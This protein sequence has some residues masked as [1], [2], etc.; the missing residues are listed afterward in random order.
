M[1][2]EVKSSFIK[3]FPTTVGV[4]NNAH[5]LND[6]EKEVILNLERVKNIGNEKSVDTFVLE[7]EELSN[8]KESMLH[9]VRHYV[10]NV[11]CW[12]LEKHQ[13]VITLSWCNYAVRGQSHPAHTHANSI[14]SGVYY[15]QVE[16]NYDMIQFSRTLPNILVPNPNDTN[17]FEHETFMMYPQEHDLLLFPS[18]TIHSVPEVLKGQRVSLAFN[19]FAKG[20]LGG[21]NELTYLKL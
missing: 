14:V 3:M 17:E 11:Q 12:N 18:N 6:N 20:D 15:P 5:V 4:Y 8:L 19:V 7:H 16:H 21:I 10:E 9:C 2:Q 1:T 13:P